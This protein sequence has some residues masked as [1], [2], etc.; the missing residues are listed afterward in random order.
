MHRD[1]SAMGRNK[2]FAEAI[3]AILAVWEGEPPYDIQLPENRFNPPPRSA[4]CILASATWPNRF[5]N[6]GRR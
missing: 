5:R 4:P 1:W 2:L 3:Q 6:R